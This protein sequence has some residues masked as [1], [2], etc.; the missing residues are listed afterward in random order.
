[1]Y[2]ELGENFTWGN[3]ALRKVLVTF[4]QLRKKVSKFRVN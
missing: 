1:M 2:P 3:F 4:G